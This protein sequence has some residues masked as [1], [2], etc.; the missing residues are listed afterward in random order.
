MKQYFFISFLFFSTLLLISSCE[1]EDEKSDFSVTL[2]GKFNIQA[3]LSPFVVTNAS[4]PDLKNKIIDELTSRGLSI[5]D[6][7]EVRSRSTRW[8][9]QD[10]SNLNYIEKAFMLVDKFQESNIQALEFAFTVDEL[11]LQSTDRITI[12]PGLA[13]IKTYADDSTID[14][15]AKY[16][17]RSIPT[18]TTAIDVIMEFDIYLN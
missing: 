2:N 15:I 9:S 7:S 17:V 18:Q 12:V 4:I 13:N 11:P 8:I 14:F 5:N 10:G 1:K 16:K 6:V 3:G